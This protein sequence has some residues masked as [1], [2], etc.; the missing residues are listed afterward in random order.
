MPTTLDG[1]KKKK[2]VKW[3]CHVATTHSAYTQCDLLHCVGIDNQINTDC[4]YTPQ[5]LTRISC[6]AGDTFIFWKSLRG[7]GGLLV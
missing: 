3:K 6:A 2:N 5:Y 7:S 1:C 4:I